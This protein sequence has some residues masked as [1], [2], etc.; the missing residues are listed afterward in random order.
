[1]A[2][3][4]QLVRDLKYA[5]PKKNRR[6]VQNKGLTDSELPDVSIVISVYNEEGVIA[7]RIRNCLS[8]DYPA[9]KLEI[10]IASDGSD[11]RTTSIVEEFAGDGIRLLTYNE[12]IGKT[13]V[14]NRSIPESRGSILLLTDSNTIFKTDAVLKLVRHFSDP[15]IG[16]VCGNLTVK[17]FDDTTEEESL[18]WKF[19][20]VL[21]LME[22]RLDMT[23]GANGGIYA[24]R[25]E[26][27]TPI[28][29]GTIV[30]DF[31]VFL[32]V[33]TK[34]Y[35][36]IFDPEAVAVEQAAPSL[37]DEYKRKV[38]IGA[39]DFQAI[40]LARRF[41]H[42]KT[43]PVCFSF[44]SHKV[45]RWLVPFF[46]IGLFLSNLALANNSLFFSLVMFFQLVFYG[47]FV[48]GLFYRENVFFRIPYYFVSMNMALL[49]GF[50]RQI[51]GAQK[52]AWERTP[53]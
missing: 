36:T 14:L 21:K 20:N 51:R 40:G 34:G 22:S 15:E 50:T 32:N 29:N 13:A 9:D 25:R 1:M 53:R 46:M 10:I 27:F 2:S 11:D 12:R 35:K 31:V 19:E 8:L 41:L 52:G 48:V 24:I 26:A 3:V 30:D 28:P 5:I 7:D 37:E 6:A 38:R 42:P 49:H 44:W 23:L 43:G 45:L 16:G 33:R 47:L 4:V 17:P 39:G 18:Y